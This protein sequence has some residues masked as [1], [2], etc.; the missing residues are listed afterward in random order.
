LLKVRPTAGE[1]TKN[2]GARHVVPALPNSSRD[3]A[4]RQF[5]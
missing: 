2:F 3:T 1:P 4:E 5:W